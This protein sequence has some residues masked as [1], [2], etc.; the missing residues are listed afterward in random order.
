MGCKGSKQGGNV[1]PAGG[2]IQLARGGPG[3]TIVWGDY[4]SSETRAILAILKLRDI[5]HG[6]ELVDT[7]KNEH[8]KESYIKQSYCETIPMV[9]NNE[10]KFVGGEATLRFLKNYY[11]QV[12]KELYPP[13]MEQNVDR[14]LGWFYNK[15]RP[16]TQR[17]IRMIYL[18]K[19]QST[20]GVKQDEKVALWDSIFGKHGML[21]NLEGYL[22]KTGAFICG[23]NVTIADIAIYCELVTLMK[24]TQQTEEDLL[25]RGLTE[26]HRWYAKLNQFPCFKEG[27]DEL[28]KLIRDNTLS[29][30][31]HQ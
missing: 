22:A 16:D 5:Q 13:E 4:M 1:R 20:P 30:K 24:L 10:L 3:K 14:Y 23:G 11:P 12:G 6:F 26:T 29:E 28:D 31:I 15:L 8:K 7:F 19:V 2:D 25:R 9:S 18:P 21:S 17:L 27:N